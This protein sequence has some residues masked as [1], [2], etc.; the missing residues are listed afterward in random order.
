MGCSLCGS[1]ESGMTEQLTHSLKENTQAAMWKMDHGG[2]GVTMELGRSACI[3]SG[4]C[5]IDVQ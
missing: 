2:Q 4:E 3:L 5:L 1:K